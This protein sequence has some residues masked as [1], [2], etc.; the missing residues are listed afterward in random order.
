ML[1]GVN[2]VQVYDAPKVDSSNADDQI[3]VVG[4][5]LLVWRDEA[6]FMSVKCICIIPLA[7]GNSN[8]YL[9]VFY[10]CHLCNSWLNLYSP[11]FTVIKIVIHAEI[12]DRFWKGRKKCRR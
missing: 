5:W 6:V 11:T 9:I 3:Q 2:V 10:S 4:D 12:N 8:S 1:I 7:A